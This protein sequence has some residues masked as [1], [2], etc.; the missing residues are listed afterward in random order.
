MIY[1]HIELLISNYFTIITILTVL[2][3]TCSFMLLLSVNPI[4]SL[5]FLVLIFL[6]TTCVFLLLKIEFISMLFLV[7]YLGAIIVLFLFVVMMLNIRIL[8]LNEKIITYFPISFFIFFSIFL[9]LI[10]VLIVNF[11]FK[12]NFLT[13]FFSFINNSENWVNNSNYIES[14]INLNDTFNTYFD[15]IFNLTNLH[16]IGIILYTE[17]IHIFIFGS[18]ILLIGMLGAIILTL[19]SKI[20]TKQQNY[21]NQNSKNILK[22]I[23]KIK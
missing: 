3:L 9:T 21:Y 4:H 20:K 12:N 5:L 18:I 11:T 2:L 10:K 1:Q 16:N 17:Y 6:L 7:V 23:K 14:E 15:L 19:Q 8:S 13:N 22:S